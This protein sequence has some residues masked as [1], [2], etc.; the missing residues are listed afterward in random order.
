MIG[1]RLKLARA[2]RGLSLRG[3][4]EKLNDLVSAQALGKYERDEMMPSSEV[5]ISLAEALDVSENYLLS[6]GEVE[7]VDVEFRKLKMT[8]T[9][10]EA[11]LKAQVLSAV[12]RYL[13][14]EDIVAADSTEWKP[15][16]GFPCSVPTMEQ[17][18]L[19][20]DRLRGVW[21]LGTDPI[22]GLAEFL[23]EM[24]IKVLS[25]D[26]PEG[27]SGMMAKVHRANGRDV[28]VIVVNKSHPGERQRFT[29]AH[30]LGH[31]ILA[32]GD[33]I[34]VEKVCHRFAGAFLI[35]RVLLE[36]EVGRQRQR[37]SWAE[38][39]RL[40]SLFGAS[41]Q[42][43]VY[44]LKDL[45]IIAEAVFSQMFRFMSRQGWRGARGEPS[46]VA[47]E[48]THRFER[49]CFRALV[50]ELISES[51]AAELLSVTVRELNA[52][53]DQGPLTEA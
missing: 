44:R 27:V 3:L 50:E 13:E 43:I 22:P 16:T 10:E 17:A 53:L 48:E 29:L 47:K 46:P 32:V 39:F 11:S 4:A 38:L 30:E 6:T 24:G 15:P 9:K 21:S 18:E 37:V 19:A 1:G 25:L 36:A 31:L 20:A 40:K 23:E 49:L 34:D 26:L 14:I 12:E 5:L 35:P 7:L 28:P 42:A 33:G 45:G 41:V 52:M 2:S 51:K 8:G